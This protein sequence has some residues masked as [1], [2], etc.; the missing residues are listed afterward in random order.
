[1]GL[2]SS[3]P[4]PASLW[5]KVTPLTVCC[6]GIVNFTNTSSVR[7]TS[8]KDI[9]CYYYYDVGNYYYDVGNYYYDVGNYYYYYDNAIYL[10]AN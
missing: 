1:M 10:R 5:L 9:I 6:A 7:S 8:S 4:S 3:K 2:S